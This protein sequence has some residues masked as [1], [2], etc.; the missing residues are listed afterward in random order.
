MDFIYKAINMSGQEVSGE[1]KALSLKEAEVL[2]GGMDLVPFDV[3]EQK[4]IQNG[5]NF[6][7]LSEKL[8]S[9]SSEDLVLFTKQLR[10]MLKAGVNIIKI[11]DILAEQTENIKLLK[12]IT[13]IRKDLNEGSSIFDAFSM[14]KSVFSSLYCSMIEAGE[15]SGSLPDI[16]ERL[17]Y[18]IEHENKIKSDIKS[19]LRY[20]A[21]VVVTLFAAFIILLTFVI[22]K[23]VVIFKKA[24]IELPLPTKIC[25]ALYM[26]IHSYWYLLIGGIVLI[27][28]GL[29]FYMKTSQGKFV[30]DTVILALPIVGPLI[31]KSVMA[32][33]A[34]VFAI[35]L[36]SGVAILNS[37]EVLSK[38]IGNSAI[39]R[40]FEMIAEKLKEG[41]GIS[42][43]LKSANYFTTMVINMVAIGEEEGS[44]DEM[45][46]EVATHYDD[47]VEYAVKG[48]AEAIG[49]LLT[50]GLAV[51]VG[52]FALAIF[53]PMWDLTKMVK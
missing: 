45:L 33:F 42:G 17:I 2:I 47:E 6:A 23:F 46:R 44:L 22:P 24:G 3:A 51:V 30:R 41:Q 35:L 38:T 20:P 39:T 43:P 4:E 10:T 34:S 8:T 19:A 16:L 49:P 40:Q 36:T 13:L 53:L 52:F 29:Y 50:I 12:T 7:G 32:R 25:I 15:V 28:S 18:I 11:L 21:I 27:G 14:H 5:V 1:V 9:V 26:V 31:I 48:L 37:L